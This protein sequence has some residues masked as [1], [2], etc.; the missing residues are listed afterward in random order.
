MTKSLRRLFCLG[1]LMAVAA[2]AFTS[3][4]AEDDDM[5]EGQIPPVVHEEP[6]KQQEPEK[7]KECVTENS[8][9]RRLN[10]VNQFYV[11]LTNSC[12][13]PHVCVLKA[14]V[15]GSEGGKAGRG[16]VRIAAAS[17]GQTAHQTWIMRTAENGGMA[18]M[19]RN[20]APR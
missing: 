13:K 7:P 17:Q 1:L 2:V 9:F 8:G 3:A 18:T 19:S 11:E 14:Y 15:V 5:P 12:D 16:T 20:C 10:G 6:V 4:H